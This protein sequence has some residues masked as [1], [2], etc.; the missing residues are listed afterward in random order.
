MRGSDAKRAATVDQ[1]RARAGQSP[2][3]TA[4]PSLEQR[5]DAGRHPRDGPGRR[6]GACVERGAVTANDA[7]TGAALTRRDGDGHGGRAERAGLVQREAAAQDGDRAASK[8]GRQ[9][10]LHLNPLSGPKAGRA[11]G[12]RR[13][14]AAT[15][16]SRPGTA[17]QIPN[18]SVLPNRSTWAPPPRA[19]N[20]RSAS[21]THGRWRRSRTS[22]SRMAKSGPPRSMRRRDAI[23]P[24]LPSITSS[25]GTTPRPRSCTL[26]TGIP[27]CLACATHAAACGPLGS[28]TT[29]QA[30]V[31][32]RR[33]RTLSPAA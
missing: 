7:H 3:S 28:S 14:P 24:T 25:D 23:G 19:I 4:W 13:S 16:T 21:R 11:G 18:A 15:T 17:R 8:L 5:D 10:A 1:V 30:A 2:S 33:T 22:G 32:T 29:T 20:T 6:R 27:R 12:R 26:E 9:S 31:R